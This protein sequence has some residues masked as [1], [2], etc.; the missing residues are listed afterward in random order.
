MSE[1][2]PSTTRPTYTPDGAPYA[3]ESTSSYPSYQGGV[4]TATWLRETLGMLWRGKWIL[5]AALA[6]AVGA[7]LVYLMT[8][9]PEYEASNLLLVHVDEDAAMAEL[10]FGAG[11]PAGLLRQRNLANEMYVL[12]QSAAIAERVARRLLDAQVIPATGAPLT[13][14]YDEDGNLLPP[15]Q[16]ETRIG[17]YVQIYPE[18]RDIDGIRV[19]GVSTVPAEAAFIANIYAEEYI[20]RTQETS[21]AR[22]FASRT[23]LEQQEAKLKQE[24]E[25][26]E[27]QVEAYMS[28]ES[29]AA[30]DEEA[31]FTVSQIA[32]LEVMLDETRV[33]L[34]MEEASLRTI[35]EE[36]E[37]IEPRLVQRMASG[38]ERSLEMAQAQIA[39]MELRLEQ[40]YLRNP[41]QREQ[42]TA[43]AELDDLNDQIDKLRALAERLS[44]RYVKEVLAIGGVDPRTEEGTNLSYVAQRQQQ[45]AEA[46]IQING[47]RAKMDVLQDRLEEYRQK[48]RDIPEQA[49]QLA[50]LQRASQSTERLY[51]HLVER[52]QETRIAEESEIGYAEVIRAASVPSFP[53]RP[54]ERRTVVVAILVGL[55]LGGGLVLL[56]ERL[57][58]RVHHAE[59]LRAQGQN[60]IGVIPD[61]RPAIKAAFNGE[62]QVRVG[63]QTLSTSL[64][65]LLQPMDRPAEAYRQLRTNIQ[66]SRP[67]AVVQTLLVTSPEAGE[68]KTTTAANLALAMAQAGR[69][70]VVVDADLRRPQLHT[71]LDIPREPG[72]AELLFSHV[73][74]EP[75]AFASGIRDLHVIPAGRPVTNPAELLG[76][77][78]M[79]ELIEALRAQFDVVLFD[80]P[81]VLAFSDAMLLSTQCDG[82]LLLATANRTDRQAM[83]QAVETIE[84]VGGIVVGSVLNRSE[85]HAGYRY[86]GNTY[87]YGVGRRDRHRRGSRERRERADET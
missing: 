50:Q 4:D 81:P 27:E 43:D 47:L 13:I 37:E 19:T 70:T 3:P 39:E 23:F 40:Y 87:A 68:G 72:L 59:D 7:A 82:T 85:A 57:D 32:A 28:S 10:D 65:M 29:A 80:A 36:L 51:V 6:V 48:M 53:V 33:Q 52:L 24:L 55:V 56:R 30:L 71:T 35:M 58:T 64:A 75:S 41:G 25:S 1:R 86:Y 2:H 31:S 67:D 61:M 49:I 73:G 34:G 22:I 78:K 16:V 60:V 26:L 8:F 15:E 9:E 66:F 5:L 17:D 21:R 76:S 42:P 83:A 20:A 11:S 38:A 14:L 63:D 77:R 46:R 74:F 44:E 12:R 69:R 84:G 62:D 18:G 54:N 79:R 45:M